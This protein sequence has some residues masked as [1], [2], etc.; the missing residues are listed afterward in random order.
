M[1]LI[2]NSIPSITKALV[3]LN[4]YP[5]RRQLCKLEI[6]I[7]VLT[8]IIIILPHVI[9]VVFYLR[10][11]LELEYQY[12]SLPQFTPALNEILDYLKNVTLI[13]LKFTCIRF[14][15]HKHTDST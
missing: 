12:G 2:R 3:E 4:E 6:K 11:L 15:L 5:E 13:L 1:V 7:P 8:T 10:H 9:Y 14:I